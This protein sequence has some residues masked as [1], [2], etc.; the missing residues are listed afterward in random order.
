[1]GYS[2]LEVYKRGYRLALE[3]HKLTM[4][5]PKH[6]LYE[7]G[8]QLRRAAISIPLN[9]AE[10]Y[11]R[12]EYNKDFRKFLI[13]S[14]AS[15]NEVMVLINMVKD[16][17]YISDQEYSSLREDYDHLIKKLNKLILSVKESP[18]AKTIL[19]PEEYQKC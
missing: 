13:T 14:R 8:S 9:I 12:Q 16:L 2:S 6:E 11:G 1:M 15:G 10:G 3:M 5:F 19:T 17:G 4:R 18:L 7:I